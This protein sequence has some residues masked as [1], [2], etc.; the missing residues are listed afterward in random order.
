[1]YEYSHSPLPE[2]T[3]YL[4]SAVRLLGPSPTNNQQQSLPP[5]NP[6]HISPP[7]VT[8]SE[9]PP[10]IAQNGSGGHIHVSVDGVMSGIE[11][12]GI[13]VGLNMYPSK[14]PGLIDTI[15]SQVIGTATKLGGKPVQGLVDSIAENPTVLRGMEAYRARITG[16][17][18]A[19]EELVGT[20]EEVEPLL[21][22]ASE[23]GIATTGEALIG[24]EAA[25]TVGTVVGG[26]VSAPVTVALA[27]AALIGLGAYEVG[28]HVSWN[29]ETLNQHVSDGFKRFEQFGNVFHPHH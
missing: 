19:E 29:G 6:A 11:N 18:V 5:T 23:T 16:T 21:G 12:I 14:L 1:M 28:K 4:S 22:A 10:G 3:A 13:G 7:S 9:H 27:G 17:T 26:I 25:E 24:V 15:G 8:N 20:T 2:N